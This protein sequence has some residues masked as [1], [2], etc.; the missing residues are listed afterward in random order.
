MVVRIRAARRA[1]IT[2]HRAAEMN[3]RRMRQWG[4]R[5][6]ISQPAKSMTRSH[7]FLAPMRR[8]VIDVRPAEALVAT[9]GVKAMLAQAHA[10]GKRA[11]HRSGRKA[12]K[13]HAAKAAQMIAGHA[14]T[15]PQVPISRTP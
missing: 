8:A 2:A 9:P 11:L 13:V 1:K 14:A 3:A 7:L 4:N 6:W 15:A 10:L 12:N 5:A